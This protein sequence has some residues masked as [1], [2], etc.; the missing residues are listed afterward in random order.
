MKFRNGL[1]VFMIL[2]MTFIVT[3][4]I[5]MQREGSDLVSDD[6]YSHDRAYQ[7]ELKAI[8]NSTK[9]KDAFNIS[10]SKDSIIFSFLKSQKPNKVDLYFMRPNN[11][12]LDKTFELELPANRNFL[13]PK[14][15]FKTGHYQVEAKYTIAGD[16]CLQRIDIEIK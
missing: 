10:Q 5:L 8:Q 7:N 3:L 15:L 13:M 2:F 9:H 1:V 16:N 4:G 11:K 14:S 6:Y 12:A